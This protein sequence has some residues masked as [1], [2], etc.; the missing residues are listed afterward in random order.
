LEVWARFIS[1]R[2]GT[3]GG[4]CER[5]FFTKLNGGYKT[6][7]IFTGSWLLICPADVISYIHIL[8]AI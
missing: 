6:D 7:D 1:Q 4:F 8:S 2:T 5:N 3:G